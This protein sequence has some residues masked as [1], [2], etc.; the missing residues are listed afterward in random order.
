MLQVFHYIN[1]VVIPTKI[2]IYEINERVQ[3]IIK[4]KQLPQQ[5]WNHI[6]SGFFRLK[7]N[8]FFK[9]I[10]V[11]SKHDFIIPTTNAFS[12]WGVIKHIVPQGL[13]FGPK[14]FLLYIND[15]S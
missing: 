14:C 3:I 1:F 10:F 12:N 13:I 15:V 2:I 5:N 11:L 6:F 7:F 8:F 4:I 9:L